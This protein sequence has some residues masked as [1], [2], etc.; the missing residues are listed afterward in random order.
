MI[1]AYKMLKGV[2]KEDKASL[3]ELRE[4]KT[5]VKCVRRNVRKYS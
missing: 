2:S 4:S 1:T 5:T 3:I